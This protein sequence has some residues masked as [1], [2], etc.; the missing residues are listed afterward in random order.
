MYK[1]KKY[2]NIKNKYLYIEKKDQVFFFPFFFIKSFFFLHFLNK[3]FFFLL[4]LNKSFFFLQIFKQYKINLN[5]QNFNKI[6]KIK[7]NYFN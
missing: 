5:I 3:S 1:E 2:K 7:L 4:I 6:K